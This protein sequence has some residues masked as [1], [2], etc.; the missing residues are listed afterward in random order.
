MSNI[1][2][3]THVNNAVSIKKIRED[4]ENNFRNGYYCCEAVLASI[5]ENI[6]PDIPEEFIAMTTGMAVGVGGAGCM[7]GALNGGIMALGMFFGRSGRTNHTDPDA[8]KCMRLANELHDWFR[9]ENGKHSACCR[10]LIREF[11]ESGRDHS[12]QC[13]YFTGLCA[14]KTAEIIIR[15]MGLKN[16]NEE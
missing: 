3:I 10:V 2:N 12:A 1:A 8:L 14:Q 15:E 5:R 6:I 4:A 11:K 7:C 16:I 9:E 13:V